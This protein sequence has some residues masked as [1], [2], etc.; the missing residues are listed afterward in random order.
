VPV[1]VKVKGKQFWVDKGDTITVDRF[2]DEI[3]AKIELPAV[4]SVVE[5]SKTTLTPKVT[6]SAVVMA[7][8][9]GTKIRV[10]KHHAKKRYRK[11]QGH[12]QQQTIL[13]IEQIETK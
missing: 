13:K 2:L 11:T 8:T 12:R 1:L 4:L 3:N 5:K 9:Q 7:H 10:F 6:V